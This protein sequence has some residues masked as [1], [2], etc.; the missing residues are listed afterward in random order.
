M[1]ILFDPRLDV[2]PSPQRA[3]WPHLRAAKQL[4]F[5]LYGGTAIALHLGH[6]NSVD[7]DFFR[8]EPLEKDRVWAE[9]AC[10]EGASILRDAPNTLIVSTP[11][12]GSPVKVAFYGGLRIGRV[13]D[14]FKTRDGVLLVASLDDLMATKLKV[15]LDRAEAKDYRDIAA[16]LAAGISLP[17][18]LAGFRRMYAGE[19][20][21][22][23]RALS[24]FGDGDLPTLNGH[25]RRLIATARNAVRQ[26][27]EV[28]WSPGPLSGGS[29]RPL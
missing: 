16:M 11:V 18:G 3:L 14:P 10:L 1:P 7:F 5:V 8:T 15:I 13:S 27:P 2:L 20:A 22:V 4:G 25:D 24:Y 17:L 28:T 6:R 19:P 12:T 23:L 9:F 21:E 26:L 29:S